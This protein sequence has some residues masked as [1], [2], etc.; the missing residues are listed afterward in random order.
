MTVPRSRSRAG[1]NWSAIPRAWPGVRGGSSVSLQRSAAAGTKT[2]GRL[3]ATSSGC[4]DDGRRRPYAP[5]PRGGRGVG[6]ACLPAVQRAV[7]SAVLGAWSM[8]VLPT[9]IN[10]GRDGSGRGTRVAQPCWSRSPHARATPRGPASAVMGL[11]SRWLVTPTFECVSTLAPR[12]PRAET[13]AARSVEKSKIKRKRYRTS[14]CLRF[15]SRFMG[16]TLHFN[17][18]GAWV[19]AAA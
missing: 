19:V 11:I 2:C 17:M 3:F 4:G 6:E 15:L 10:K 14:S 1:A 16:W 8:P 12:R 13:R 7:C 18:H 5:L 9:C